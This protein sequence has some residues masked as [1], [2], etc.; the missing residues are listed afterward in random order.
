MKYNDINSFLLMVRDFIKQNPGLTTEERNNLIYK[1]LT[2]Q[3]VSFEDQNRDFVSDGT[4]NR[5]LYYFNN[6]NHIRAFINPKHSYFCVFKNDK[7]Q[8]DQ[9]TESIKIYVPQDAFHLE[10]TARLIFDFLDKNNFCHHSKIGKHVRFDDIVIRMK[11]KNEAQKLLNFIKNN[12]FIQEGLI[13]P[14]PFAFSHNNIAMACDRDMSYNFTVTNLINLYM[15]NI[16]E[17]NAFDRVSVEDYIRFINI[18]YRYHFVKY[19][20]LGDTISDFNIAGANYNDIPSNEKIVNLRDI[21]ELHLKSMDPSYSQDDF[22]R[23]YEERLNPNIVRSKATKF[24]NERVK[25]S[26]ITPDEL[27]EYD[28]LLFNAVD[29]LRKKYPDKG[30]D[31]PLKRLEYYIDSGIQEYIT[32][33]Y[34]LRRLLVNKDFARVFKQR[35]NYFSC[36]IRY[37]YYKKLNDFNSH[38]L[39]SAIYETYKKYQDLYESKKIDTDGFTWTRTALLN[40]IQYNDANGFTRQNDVRKDLINYLTPTI[41]YS[42][43]Q[44]VYGKDIPNENDLIVAIDE[45]IRNVI[46]SRFSLGDKRKAV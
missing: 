20:D 3:G 23:D 44:R 16:E 34:H 21:L 7:G 24:R 28:L 45:Y 43:V 39:N 33:D 31:Y 27:D 42:N 46:M 2:R 8:F 22:F 14:N 35:L 40:Y 9:S 26:L 32:R 5:L 1:L 4:F 10:G 6:R 29:Q 13:K 25:A 30:E 15:K 38:V 19:N 37:Y 17:N 11:D 41:V 18:Y 36:D 12:K